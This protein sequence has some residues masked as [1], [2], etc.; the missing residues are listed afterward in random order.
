MTHRP[1]GTKGKA[2]KLLE[3]RIDRI[4]RKYNRLTVR[5]FYYIMISRFGYPP[6]RRFYKRFVYH[7]SKVRQFNPKLHAKIVDNTREFIPALPSSFHRVELWVE[8]DAIRMLSEDLAAKYRM[9]IQ[10]L[11]GFPSIT[12]LRKASL[13]EKKQ[14]IEKILYV[15]D[16]DPSGVLIPQFAALE[17]AGIEFQ[18]IAITPEQA[19]RYRL[20][21][22]GINKRDSRAHDYI[23][24]NGSKAWKLEAL[25]PRTFRKIL[26]GELKSNVPASFLRRAGRQEKAVKIARP[27]ANRIE[28]QIISMLKGRKSEREIRK[29]LAS[30]FG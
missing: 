15:G 13:R 16:F 24:K 27:I 19:R 4:A 26:E 22:I 14:G 20:P 30:R 23:K 17:M 29:L 12:M 25:R 21:A 8:K 5:Q 10:V 3:S 2:S 1:R 9:S 6:G 28:R 18:R 7:L 11:R